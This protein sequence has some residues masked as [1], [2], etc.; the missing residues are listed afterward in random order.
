MLSSWD[1]SAR[2]SIDKAYGRIIKSMF[3]ILEAESQQDV[4]DTKATTEEKEFL[5]KYILIVGKNLDC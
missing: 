4:V 3:D 2:K 1:G 5:N